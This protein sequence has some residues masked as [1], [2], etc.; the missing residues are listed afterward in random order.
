[1]QLVNPIFLWALT[2]LSIPIGIHLLSRK[3]GK[4]I[5]LG[6]L[7]H[8]HETSTQQ[9]RGIRL[10]EILLLIL[11]CLL[12]V[13]FTLILSGLHW[14]NPT[15]TKW[16]LLEKGLEKEHQ[17]MIHLDSLSD[18]GYEP[19]ILTE[20]FPL[21]EDSADQS[22][23][24]NY[25]SLM[26]DLREKDL[27]DVIIFAQNSVN[28]FKGSR[29]RLPSHVRWIS[30]SLPGVDYD[31]QSVMTTKDSVVVRRGHTNAEATYFTSEGMTRSSAIDVDAPD[32][33]RVAIASDDKFAYDRLMLK[34]ALAA[35]DQTFPLELKWT[36]IKPTDPLPVSN[37]LIW[38]S[39][40][41][42]PNNFSSSLLYVSP[43]LSNAQV[44]FTQ[45]KTNQWIIGKRLN[46]DV[47]LQEN[48]TIKLASLLL[49]KEELQKK[50]DAKDRRMMADALA[51][52]TQPESKHAAA[53]LSTQANPYL[54]VALMLL[55]FVERVIA[56]RRNQ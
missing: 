20:N 40:S 45:A 11:R 23:A 35:I 12:I 9:F 51:W 8:V 43:S 28:K 5:R 13:L 41:D 46:E 53:M 26:E 27:S 24:T 6:S 52:S 32:T 33:I 47:A 30:R 36:E 16:I 22:P 7:R 44:L 1:M 29:P 4:V 54:I 14:N 2:G 10:N 50:A 37:W 3:E 55:L 31:L 42:T 34:A 21:L 18:A 56:Y 49:P 19:R 17:L 15:K 38:L 25:Y 48:L 39:D